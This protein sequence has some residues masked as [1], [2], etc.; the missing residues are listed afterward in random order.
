MAWRDEMV[1][2][3]LLCWS[4]IACSSALLVI[5][6]QITHFVSIEQVN[7]QAPRAMLPTNDGCCLT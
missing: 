1:M 3:C 2:R 4:G 7:V 6:D 5:S